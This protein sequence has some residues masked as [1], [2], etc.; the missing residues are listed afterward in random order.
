MNLEKTAIL[1]IDV[2]V[3]LCAPYGFAAKL[4]R[5]IGPMQ[6]MLPKLKSFYRKAKRMGVPIFFTQ[7]IARKDISPKNVAIN[8]NREE[9]ARLCLLNSRGS[10]T[11]FLKPKD[12][13]WL[14]KKR[15]Y[16]AFANTNLLERL[17]KL[18]IDT[19]VLAGVRTELGVDAT[20]KRAVAEGFN[21][22]ILSDLVGTYKENQGLHQS[23]LKVF[24]RYYGDV[25]DSGKFLDDIE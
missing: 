20:A 7:Y 11:Y 6:E 14:V 24:Q 17:L 4:G 15:Y 25:M 23:F 21:V 8:R 22:V 5:D 16:D 3:D 18:K 13:D 1:I 2:Q 10:E 19:L 12:G 9:R